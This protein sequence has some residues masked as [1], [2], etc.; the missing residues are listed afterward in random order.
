MLNFYF[1]KKHAKLFSKNGFYLDYY[2]KIKSIKILKI[3]YIYMYQFFGEKYF[4]E[5]LFRFNIITF[6]FLFNKK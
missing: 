2:F 5:Y 3:Y 6:I 4:L 1:L